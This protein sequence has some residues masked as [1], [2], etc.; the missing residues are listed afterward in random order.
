MVTFKNYIL[1]YVKNKDSSLFFGISKMKHGNN[2]KDWNRVHLRKHANTVVDEYDHKH[3]IIDSIVRGNANNVPVTGANLNN[4]L[5]L[6]DTIFEIGLKTLGNSSVE[7]EMFEDKHG[8][9]HGK[10]RNKKAN[11]PKLKTNIN[12]L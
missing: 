3:P 10:L 11:K 8:R 1:E 12:G 5:R 4:I 9:Q 2:G 7:I 6:Y